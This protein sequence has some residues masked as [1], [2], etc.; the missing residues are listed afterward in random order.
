MRASR[1]KKKTKDRSIDFLKLTGFTAGLADSRG[2]L[3]K[4]SISLVLALMLL[5][6]TVQW[7]GF[8]QYSEAAPVAVPDT[9]IKQTLLLQGDN[10]SNDAL[11]ACFSTATPDVDCASLLTAI[12]YGAAAPSYTGD[13]EAS[14]GATNYPFTLAYDWEIDDNVAEN[15]GTYTFNLPAQLKLEDDILDVP[16]GAAGTFSVSKASKTITI[17]FVPQGGAPESRQKKGGMQINAW[18]E[19]TTVIENR[20]V[21]VQIP[22]NASS[23]VTVKIPVDLGNPT[24]SISKEMKSVDRTLN[25]SEVNWSIDV[26]KTLGEV[27]HVIVEDTLPADLEL[28][29]TS[30]VVVPLIVSMN[31]T[32]T[33]G[34]ALTEGPSPGPGPGPDY[35]LSSNAATNKFTI[36]FGPTDPINPAP[37]YRI[38]F[39]TKVK[40]DAV[41]PA[42]PAAPK[43]LTNYVKLFDGA[44]EKKSASADVSVQRGP[45]IKKEAGGYD[46]DDNHIAIWTLYFNFGQLELTDPVLTD[47]LP[48]GH[49][50]VPGSMVVETINVAAN[51]S[52]GTVISSINAGAASGNYAITHTPSGSA[53]VKDSFALKLIGPVD[54]AYR[55]VYKTKAKAIAPVIKNESKTNSLTT[56][57]PTVTS[58]SASVSYVQRV[59]DK[60]GLISDYNS[61]V[62]DWTIMLNKNE[63][64]FEENGLDKVK[65][66]DT[67][68][69]MGLKLIPGTLS[70]KRKGSAT[71][72]VEGSANDYVLTSTTNGAGLETG[73][74]IVFNDNYLFNTEHTI[75]YQTNFDYEWF[76]SNN[77]WNK[78]NY[79][80]RNTGVF[81]WGQ[82]VDKTTGVQLTGYGKGSQS[83]GHTIIPNDNTRHNGNKSGTYDATNKKT[84][85][86]VLFNYHNETVTGAS[87]VSGAVVTDTLQADQA[88]VAGSV[89]IRPQTLAADG[90]LTPGA[91]LVEGTH[92][93]VNN[94]LNGTDPDVVTITFSGPITG[95]H[96]I[97]FETSLTGK[98]VPKTINNTATFTSGNPLF[99]ATLTASV[100]PSYGNEFIV[101][102]FKQTPDSMRLAEWTV[103]INRSLSYLNEIVIEDTPDQYQTLVKDSFV[104]YKALPNRANPSAD[105]HFTLTPVATSDYNI[106][107]LDVTPT[108]TGHLKFKLTINNSANKEAAYKLEYKSTLA[109]G[110]GSNTTNQYKMSGWGSSVTSQPTEHTFSVNKNSAS[111]FTFPSDAS[112]RGSVKVVKQADDRNSVK[113]EGA[114][115]KIKPKYGVDDIPTATTDEHGVVIFNNLPFDVYE[116]IEVTAPNGYKLDTTPKDIVI[117]STTEHLITINNVVNTGRIGNYV[118][119]DR[120]RDGLQDAD[121]TGINGITVKLYKNGET[122]AL[123][124]TTTT[125]NGSTQPGY[126]LFDNLAPGDYVVEFVWPDD[127]SLTKNVPGDAAN[128][129]NPL[130]GD[131]KTAVITIN[132]NNG[133]EDLTIDLGL[134]AK[135]EIGNYVW[136]DWDRDGLQDADEKG[137]NGIEVILFKETGGTRT[138]VARTTTANNPT[139][140]KPGYYLFEHLTRGDY[141]VQFVVPT[142][143]DKTTEKVGNN[144]EID[145][146]VT[147]TTGLTNKIVIG[148]A[149]WKDHTID[150]GLQAK[151]KIGDFVWFDKN[152]NGSQ[153]AG[154][155]GIENIIVE[156]YKKTGA[157]E[158]LVDS[159]RT[160]ADG[161][162]LFDHLVEGNYYVKF[163]TPSI[164]DLAKMEENGV[165][166][167]KDSNLI[168]KDAGPD[169]GKTVNAIPIG[170][171]G[172]VDMTIDLGFTGKGALGNYVWHDRNRNGIQDEDPMHGINGVTVNL[173]RN[174]VGGTPY[175]TD[176]TKTE[177]GKPG[178]YGFKELPQGN[179]YVEFV[180]PDEYE[181][182]K[183]ETDDNAVDGSNQTNA[184]NITNAIEISETAP[185]G[186]VNPHID[187]GLVA[188]GTIGNYVWFDVNR[189]GIQDAT[190]QGLND[191]TLRLYR[192]STAGPVYAETK[193]VNGPDGKPGYYL[194]D[195]LASGDYFVQLVLDDN[196]EVTLAEQGS[197]AGAD[198]LDSNAV[199]ALNTTVAITIG[200]LAPMAPKGW[201]DHTID[202]GIV[203][204]GAIGN[205]VW[206]DW[207]YN[208]K[209]DE[210]DQYGMNGVTVK[211][212]DSSKTLLATTFTADKDGKPG[213]YLFDHLVAGDYYV[214]FETPPFYISTRQGADGVSAAEDSNPT[215]SGFTETIAIGPV[216]PAVWQDMTIDQ[217]YYYVPPVFPT[218]TPSPSPSTDPEE[219][220]EPGITPTPTPSPGTG[221]P[222]PTPTPGTG[223]P[224]PAPTPT[225]TTVTE[226][227]PEDTPIDV[228]VDVP[229]GGTTATGTP[230]KN[231]SVTITPDGKV[232]YTPNKG[233]TG[234]DRFS[235]IIKDADGNE[236]EFWFDID[237]EEPPRGGLEGTPNVN[238]LPKTGQESYL[239]LYLIGAAFVAIGIYL[240]FRNNRKTS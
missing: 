103:W 195:N 107:F 196:H 85:W 70:I 240:R 210:E 24:P 189:N 153:D 180:F 98:L 205:Y 138:E 113:L 71:P 144:E 204:K 104:L 141:Y 81:S 151:G 117:N 35:S 239:M 198:E 108:P 66:V 72:L 4:K 115:F 34:A 192:G 15:G 59:I 42:P 6:Q 88:L 160:D 90:S 206:H 212:Y 184:S 2:S 80:F 181:K 11:L 33:E 27:G 16:L 17:T 170:P 92:Y 226:K 52:A 166:S 191:V 187:L 208:G 116:L 197:G 23:T 218:P 154:E 158:T 21:V 179:Y 169:K 41:L 161:K 100:S 148:P 230:P 102:E 238:T 110:V 114:V 173:Y 64:R 105:S 177:G 199:D 174:T 25:T 47:V 229:K 76:A 203:R 188:Q 96:L 139:D 74:E 236:E 178:Y 97:T 155:P 79:T 159:V 75:T 20:E 190:E 67:F 46:S 12:S 83:D 44:I 140:N 176:V 77:A 51:G 7:G 101:K 50:F 54:K 231:G 78:D 1:L 106:E 149:K 134:V 19:E 225:P 167:E 132:R 146:N 214:K 202:F 123:A 126:Y 233:Y 3:R 142:S 9:V 53:T 13:F 58:Q 224:T 38:Y 26:N 40:S 122:T 172:W 127:Y 30:V 95:P 222:T 89:K 121:E 48:A 237:V 120:N 73:F 56:N 22:V 147:D 28:D 232:T 150:L 175:K 136:L 118:W 131:N 69:N 128:D 221:T 124:T 156:L 62:M 94:A 133:F 183:A 65:L 29:T 125:N 185:F 37:A 36:D 152:D 228:E 235:V 14:L 87:G 60:S 86:N 111:G 82:I 119:L 213:Y 216:G 162:Y 211:L 207:N 68:N 18:L 171:A 168:V 63:Y 8:L 137:I 31:N 109:T 32:V 130:D 200:E 49:E 135:G 201:H 145:S 129:S 57:D 5:L 215:L 61:K 217:G 234:K 182:T 112:Y 164:Y 39:K 84:T 165:T 10:F 219:T 143:Y 227:T 209:Q 91:L 157:V 55:I 163:E 193:T 194:F 220:E 43:T 93:T 99:R 45:V 186:W 223:T